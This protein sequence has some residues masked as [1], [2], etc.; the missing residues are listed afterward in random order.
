MRIQND[1]LKHLKLM[2]KYYKTKK[3][4]EGFRDEKVARVLAASNKDL[5]EIKNILN[6][7]QEEPTSKINT[8]I[9]F[10]ALKEGFPALDIVIRVSRKVGM[11]GNHTF[12]PLKFVRGG[13]KGFIRNLYKIS[14]VAVVPHDD[15]ERGIIVGGLSLRYSRYGSVTSGFVEPERGGAETGLSDRSISNIFGR[16][17]TCVDQ[18]FFETDTGQKIGNGGGGGSPFGLQTPD[19]EFLLYLRGHNG[20]WLDHF[21]AV[22][23]RFK[24]ATWQ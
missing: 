17:G 18:L 24:P 1:Q 15:F 9:P 14:A 2:Y 13:E 23:A 16:C 8:A 11:G 5:E 12:I 6:Q 21:E 4:P 10:T 19:D 7:F 22:Y 20:T 3:Y